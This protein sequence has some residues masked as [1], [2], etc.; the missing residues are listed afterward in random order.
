[1]G[2]NREDTN[3]QE[4][5]IPII[6][7]RSS[8]ILKVWL[9]DYNLVNRVF[10]QQTDQ[11][12]ARE[13]LDKKLVNIAHQ[14]NTYIKIYSL[15]GVHS[16]DLLIEPPMFSEK[17]RLKTY[18]DVLTDL[19]PDMINAAKTNRARGRLRMDQMIAVR[20]IRERV[21]EIVNH[22]SCGIYLPA[23]FQGGS[24]G[25]GKGGRGGKGRAY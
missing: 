18:Y 24:P 8:K 15:K 1:M 17:V 25:S 2:Q 23:C 16:F 20:E 14:W 7:N 13:E 3:V 4:Y 10:G 11:E 5:L 9:E 21:V 12:Q 19:L 22:S 6:K